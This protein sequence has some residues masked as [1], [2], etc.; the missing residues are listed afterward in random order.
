MIARE[1]IRQKGLAIVEWAEEVPLAEL[2]EEL[3]LVVR[4]RRVLAPRTG[5]GHPS[6]SAMHGLGDFPWHTDGAQE[7]RTPHWLLLRSLGEAKT[8]T[9]LLDGAALAARSGLD[10]KLAAASWLVQGALPFYSPVISPGEGALRW[11]PD[12]MRPRGGRGLATD[13]SWRA[14]LAGAQPQRH[15]WRAGEVL[16]LD[17]RR[18]LHARPA[19]APEDL[20]RRLERIQ[21]E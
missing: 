6:L 19:V 1:E 10:A 18:W 4:D 5:G 12:L 3:G 20:E 16:I 11:N 8:P 14:L 2:A 9:L 17:N 7:V 13:A 15:P 21:C